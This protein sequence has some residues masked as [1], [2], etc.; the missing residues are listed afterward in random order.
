MKNSILYRRS[1]SI[2]LAILLV[3]GLSGCRVPGS[4]AAHNTPDPAGKVTETEE[5]PSAPLFWDACTPVSGSNNLYELHSDFLSAGGYSDCQ[6]YGNN[7]LFI[8]FYTDPANSADN[9]QEFEGENI[10]YR[11]DLYSPIDN[12]LIATVNTD[13][14]DFP[15]YQVVNSQLFLLNYASQT[16]YRYDENLALLGQYDMSLIPENTDYIFHPTSDKDI[17]YSTSY[18]GNKILKITLDNSKCLV[19]SLPTEFYAPIIYQT[20]PKGDKLLL[21]AVEPSTF[22]NKILMAESA[23]L[24]TFDLLP[25]IS[26]YD[27]SDSSVL[28]KLDY[29]NGTWML[30]DF[31]GD[32]SYFALPQNVTASLIGNYILTIDE[33]FSTADAGEEK[34]YSAT[35]YN[36]SGCCLSSFTY[37][38]SDSDISITP[39][40]IYF[41]EYDCCMMLAYTE[42]SSSYYLIVWDLSVSGTTTEELTFF[43]SPDEVPVT[44][45]PITDTEFT[46]F[47]YGNTVTLI[48][49]PDSYSWGELEDVHRRAA[50]LGEQYGVSIYLGPEI[51]EYIDYYQSDQNLDPESLSDALDQLEEILKCYPDNFFSQLCFGNLIGIRIYLTGTLRGVSSD[52]VDE[53]SGFVSEI[54]SYMVMALDSNLYYS[55]PYTVNH[56]ISHMIDRSLAFRSIYLEDAVFS[57]ETWNSY[58]PEEFV[59]LESYENYWDNPD[60]FTYAEYFIDNYGLTYATE[61]RAQHFG[62]AMNYYM[63]EDYL[64]AFEDSPYRLAKLQYYCDCIRAD[65]DT[66]GWPEELPWEKVL[67]TFSYKDF[68]N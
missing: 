52:L 42:S 8:S 54:N 55:W 10:N 20:T 21:S 68:S 37:E 2:L 62:A 13:G 22:Q 31:S 9:P 30:Y 16:L 4:S 46:E 64:F 67:K 35:C 12:A 5:S 49:D 50:A 11:F 32:Y 15:V 25:A 44:E 66:T 47:P 39:P 53:A 24:T 59:Y 17:F 58:N 51:P 60:Y 41:P 7:L 6:K 57:E 29:S 48:E 18:E 28:G 45:A 26:Y 40:P 34:S 61:D 38:V 3:L 23:S 19:E 63:T 33:N 36:F 14:L 56:E 1:F 27:I 43:S 65:F